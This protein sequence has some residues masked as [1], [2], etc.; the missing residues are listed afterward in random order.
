VSSRCSLFQHPP[1]LSAV[2]WPARCRHQPR[3]G[4]PDCH[5]QQPLLQIPLDRVP[6]AGAWRLTPTS[7]VNLD[8]RWPA[9][10][11]PRRC[12]SARMMLASVLMPAM[13]VSP[14]FRQAFR[15]AFSGRL[16]PLRPVPP[17][18]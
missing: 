16:D 14:A 11:G 1:R 7:R 13:S 15:Q 3:L 4:S 18:L 12:C 10:I 5:A 17:G 9:S 2:R 6:C 8:G